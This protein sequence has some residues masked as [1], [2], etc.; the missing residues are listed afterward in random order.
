MS[1][2]G[3]VAGAAVRTCCPDGCWTANS[4]GW[5]CIWSVAGH[6]WRGPTAAARPIRRRTVH[7]VP[8]DDRR[9]GPGRGRVRVRR[10]GPVRTRWPRS[11]DSRA[12]LVVARRARELWS[13]QN[14]Q[15]D[16]CRAGAQYLTCSRVHRQPVP[17]EASISPASRHWWPY[18]WPARRQATDHRRE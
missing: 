10:R 14:R 18:A 15:R 16:E 9:G 12:R 5:R 11:A 1:A 13:S 17:S 4:S 6:V 7:D 3:L 8:A 2:G